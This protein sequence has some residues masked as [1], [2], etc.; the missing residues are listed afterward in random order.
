VLASAYD[1][2]IRKKK[3]RFLFPTSFV[4][5]GLMICGTASS[6]YSQDAVN[7]EIRI[8]ML[9]ARPIVFKNAAMMPS[10]ALNS[11]IA[12]QAQAS[13]T[14]ASRSLKLRWDPSEGAAGYLVYWG[15]NPAHYDRVE[16]VGNVTE[17]VVS[18]LDPGSRYFF[19]VTAYSAEGS[20]SGFTAE[21]ASE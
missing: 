13:A 19:N 2:D 4:L 18:D 12:P 11:R 21:A 10:R 8:G 1:C 9:R 7:G 17:A 14:S 3:M 16:D 20:Q 15:S 6:L 5:T